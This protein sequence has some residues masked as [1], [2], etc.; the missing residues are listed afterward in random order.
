MANQSHLIMLDE[1]AEEGLLAAAPPAVTLVFA[2]SGLALAGA[3]V[4]AFLS[5]ASRG[6][7]VSRNTLELLLLL[8]SMSRL[9]IT[10]LSFCPA[11]FS[12]PRPTVPVLGSPYHC[13]ISRVSGVARS[14]PK[15][16]AGILQRNR[17]EFSR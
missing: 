12:K 14:R 17:L 4:R 10:L 16:A 1:V 11:T 7:G 2:E 9:G 3:D 15:S 6:A 8:T 5:L 13:R